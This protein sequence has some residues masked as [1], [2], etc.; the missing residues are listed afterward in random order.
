MTKDVYKRLNQYE[1][2]L[3]GVRDSK[4]ARVT[5]SEMKDLADIYKEH[6]GYGLSKNEMNCSHCKFKALE[7]LGKDYFSYVPPKVGRPKK[8]VKSELNSNGVDNQ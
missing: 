6:Y 3:K 4:Y 2:I 5:S 7:R 1:G 8:E